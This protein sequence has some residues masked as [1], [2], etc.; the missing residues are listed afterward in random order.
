MMNNVLRLSVCAAVL[1]LLPAANAQWKPA[2]EQ[3]MTK[4]GKNIDVN[5]VLPE[6][7]RPQM[8]RPTWKNLNGLW[9]YAITKAGAGYEKADGKILVPFAVESALSGVGKFL[10]P[11]QSLWYERNFEIPQEWEGK[12]ILLNFGAVDWKCTVIVNGKNWAT[13]TGGY[14]PFSV[15][16]T[17]ALVKGQNNLKIR[18]EDATDAN[19]EL[20]QPCGKQALN[21]KGCFYTAVSGIWQ[22][23]WLEPVPQRY[24]RSLKITPDVDKSALN[25][26]V[27]APRGTTFTVEVLDG[28]KVVAK[29]SAKSGREAVAYIKNPKLWSPDSPFLY[30]LKIKLENGGEVLDEV[31]SYAGMRKISL[32]AKG[33]A[34]VNTEVKICLNNKPIYNY[35]PLDQGWWPDGL[36]TAPS[37][38]ALKFDIEKTKKWGFNMIRKHIKVEPA[39]W[40]YHCDKIGIIVWQDMPCCSGRY[41]GPW[42]RTELIKSDDGVV[43]K[44]TNLNYKKEFRQIIDSLWSFPSV[45]VWVPFNENWG[46][47]NTPEI[48]AW[49]KKYDPT[50]LVNAASGGNYLV[51]DGDI[52]DSHHYPEPKFH[53]FERGKANVI[54]E[55]GGLGFVQEGHTWANRKTWGYKNFK[56][57]PSM[58][59]KYDEFIGMLKN[60]VPLGICGAVYTQTTDVENETNGIMTYDREVVKFDEE[61]LRQTNKSLIES[62]K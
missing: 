27:R 57:T 19:N 24:I 48:V 3:I 29:A 59:A 35:G 41:T 43:S 54:G 55:F 53:I 4:W 22:T 25:V 62:L 17:D 15:D 2:G 26:S 44:A 13:H 51:C 20:V 6:Y 58:Q 33:R 46:Q 30:D 60:L 37:D 34:A 5:N 18:V 1:A 9:D 8:V 56:D 36:Y 52:I 11:D 45:V 14:T 7:P 23:V 38:E 50:R 39:R 31:S 40:Y 61:K 16:I 42:V 12:K 10:K 49:T 21:P 32:S 28:G 47:F